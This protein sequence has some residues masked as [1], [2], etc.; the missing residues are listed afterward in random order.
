MLPWSR[1]LNADTRQLSFGGDW[2]EE[3]LWHVRAYLQAYVTALKNQP[4]F[5]TAYIDGF[6]G[7]GTV[8]L[9]AP[10]P[11]ENLL[12]PDLDSPETVSE[13]RDYMVGS[14]KM[15]LEV[16][17]SFDRYVLIEKDGGHAR[18][19]SEMTERF[20]SLVDRIEVITDDANVAVRRLCDSWDW[21]K[22]RAVLFLDPFGMQVD[23]STIEVVARTRA[24]DMW[25]LFP[26]GAVIRLLRRDGRIDQTWGARLTAT[27]GCD[28]WGGV[29]YQTTEEAGLFGDL[30]CT[31]R[32]A[33]LE[34][35]GAYFLDRLST[36]FGGVAPMARVLCNSK[37]VPLYLLCFAVATQNVKGQTLAL[38]IANHILQMK[39]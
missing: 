29:F 6:A 21:K 30:L 34:R 25:Y 8:R 13:T 37:N 38:R 3:K 5:Q 14:A 15:A 17:P 28:D 4:Y 39:D 16:K 32:T 36:V 18:E 9:P 12:L 24:I 27:F 19:L 31:T 23:W 11:P 10:D 22:H 7:T 1:L 26:V 20:P 2:T 33:S 35:V